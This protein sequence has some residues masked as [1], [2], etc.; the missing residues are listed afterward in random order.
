VIKGEKLANLV[1]YAFTINQSPHV[2]GDYYFASH[3]HKYMED[4][5]KRCFSNTDLCKRIR[6]M[7]TKTFQIG[8]NTLGHWS[9]SSPEPTMRRQWRSGLVRGPPLPCWRLSATPSLWRWH[10]HML[11]RCI[12]CLHAKDSQKHCHSSCI[13][14]GAHPPLNTH[15]S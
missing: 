13:N 2:F 14:R 12:T 10:G 6:E 8:Q 1:T 11:R 7:P 3:K 15:S 4:F 5:T 9:M